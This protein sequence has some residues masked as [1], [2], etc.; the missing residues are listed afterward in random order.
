M[1][2]VALGGSFPMQV[3]LRLRPGEALV[4]GLFLAADL[5]R[6]TCPLIPTAR[7]ALC[8]PGVRGFP[9]PRTQPGPPGCRDR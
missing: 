3:V 1:A 8:S 6:H 2:E 4:T 7:P 9:E 5:H